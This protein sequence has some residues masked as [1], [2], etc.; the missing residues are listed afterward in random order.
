VYKE[1]ERI[2]LRFP[3]F[4]L[5]KLTCATFVERICSLFCTHIF[6]FFFSILC[7]IVLFVC[8]KFTFHFLFL[9]FSHLTISPSPLSFIY[10]YFLLSF[11]Y[12]TLKMPTNILN[13]THAYK[14]T[15]SNQTTCLK[16]SSIDSF[17]LELLHKLDFNGTLIKLH[18]YSKRVSTSNN[19][20]LNIIS[21][22]NRNYR[23]LANKQ[24][25]NPFK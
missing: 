21:Y 24:P 6:A 16:G 22:H 12:F 4:F 11:I 10:L 9:S 8:F 17:S 15:P 14:S 23:F 3:F 1:R 19:F 5:K 25:R 13:I 18:K 7:V 20:C 2:S